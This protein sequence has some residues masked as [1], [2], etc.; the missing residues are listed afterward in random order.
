MAGK[1]EPCAPP[2]LAAWERCLDQAAYAN[3]RWFMN[4]PQMHTNEVRGMV[5]IVRFA[6]D[7]FHYGLALADVERVVRLVEITS[8]PQAP[9]IV[10]GVVNVQGRIIPVVNIRKRFRLPERELSPEDQLILA[11]TWKRPVGLAVDAVAGVVELP[12]RRVTAAQ[13][14][15]HGLEYVEGVARLDDGM[16]LIHDL[17]KFLSLDEESALSEALD[18]NG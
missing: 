15:L 9:E 14:I 11:K 5:K 12:E 7:E 13:V 3:G 8:L 1:A 17:D 6:L 2:E 4:F 18:S 16:I 10:L